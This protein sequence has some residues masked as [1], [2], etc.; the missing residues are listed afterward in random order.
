MS[1]KSKFPEL[2]QEIK[3]REAASREIRKSIQ[4]TSGMERHQHWLDKRSYGQDTRHL[5]MLY[6]IARG[7]PRYA[8]EPKHLQSNEYWAVDRA[9]FELATQHNL[10]I[11]R[12][13]IQAWL[14]VPAPAQEVAA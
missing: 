2:K 6:C 13:A 10:P 3:T 7:I 12:E 1:K 8:M 4:G 5:L 11:T 14:K 9:V